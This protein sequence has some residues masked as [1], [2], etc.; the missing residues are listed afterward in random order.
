M[1]AIRKLESINFA[2][3]VAVSLFKKFISLTVWLSS[4][5]EDE[6]SIFKFMEEDYRD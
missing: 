3:Y 5:E 6:V 1:P 4:Y 2:Y